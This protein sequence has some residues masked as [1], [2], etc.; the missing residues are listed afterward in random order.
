M[1]EHNKTDVGGHSGSLGKK[2]NR[3]L[4]GVLAY[5]GPLVIVSYVSAKEDPFVKFHIKQGLLLLI[6]EVIVW[7]ISPMLMSLW[8]IANILNLAALVLAI[9]GILNVTQ[10]KEKELPFI[11]HLSRLFTF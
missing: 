7:V 10:G 6:L 9:I 11:G 2:E 4:M 5:L 3:T 8:I 1:D